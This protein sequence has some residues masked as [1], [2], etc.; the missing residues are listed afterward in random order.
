MTLV[1][2][3]Q[4]KPRNNFPLGSPATAYYRQGSEISALNFSMGLFFDVY[5]NVESIYY[6]T[7]F[8]CSYLP[9]SKPG[10]SY[11]N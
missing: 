1:F 11:Y 10:G 3:R 6:G 7:I 8:Q 2:A 9:L 5:T 4:E